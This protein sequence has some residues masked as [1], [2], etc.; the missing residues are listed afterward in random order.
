MDG[1]ATSDE[2]R[3]V[4]IGTTNRPHELDSAAMRRF[5]ILYIII[6]YGVF[7]KGLISFLI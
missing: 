1:V 6:K 3:V 2:D 7:S 4:V 5:V